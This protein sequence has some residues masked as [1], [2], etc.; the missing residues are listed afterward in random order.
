MSLAFW[1]A[2][3]RRSQDGTSWLLYKIF[4]TFSFPAISAIY[5]FLT[6]ISAYRSV[7]MSVSALLAGL[8]IYKIIVNADAAEAVVN[9]ASDQA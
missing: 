3:S 6:I 9:L 5:Q 4:G 8:A 1:W 2:S 7:G